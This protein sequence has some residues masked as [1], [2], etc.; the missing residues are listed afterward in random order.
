MFAS[1]ASTAVYTLD[2]LLLHYSLTHFEF[3]APMFIYATL[4]TEMPQNENCGR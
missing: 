1:R 4:D 3:T 2:H